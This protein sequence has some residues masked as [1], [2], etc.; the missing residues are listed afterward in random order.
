MVVLPAGRFPDAA[1]FLEAVFLAET[2]LATFFLAAGLRAVAFFTDAFFVVV[3][4]AAP[5]RPT[6][7]AGLRFAVRLLPAARRP[8]IE[9]LPGRAGYPVARAATD[10]MGTGQVANP[11]PGTRQSGNGPPCAQSSNSTR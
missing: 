8:F 5:V 2:F 3:F 1:F 7:F 9:L 4:F 10:M 11:A 6:F